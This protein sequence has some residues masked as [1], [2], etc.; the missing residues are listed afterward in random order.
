M[1]L[2]TLPDDVLESLFDSVEELKFESKACEHR[3]GLSSVLTVRLTQLHLCSRRLE[4]N[5][6]CPL[7]RLEKPPTF[8]SRSTLLPTPWNVLDG[9]R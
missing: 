2:H 9:I 5:T 8:R 4:Q 6:R 1:N 7:P 3:K